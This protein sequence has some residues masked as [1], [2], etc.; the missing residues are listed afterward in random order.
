MHWEIYIPCFDGE[1]FVFV[2]VFVFVCDFL[3]DYSYVCCVHV[4]L[5]VV[6]YPFE[7]DF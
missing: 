6:I 7:C 2:F 1:L 5:I 3:I 4:F